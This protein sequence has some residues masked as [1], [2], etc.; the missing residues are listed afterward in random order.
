MVCKSMTG[1]GQ[2]SQSSSAFDVRVELRSVNQRFVEFAL[3][4]SKDLSYLEEPI[5]A[6]LGKHIHRGRVDVNVFLEARSTE[7]KVDIQWDVLRA[8][9]LAEQQVRETLLRDAAPVSI[10]QLLLHPQVTVVTTAPLSGEEVVRATLATLEQATLQ[11][12]T[13]RQR[14]GERLALD[15]RA[16]IRDLF[17][18]VQTIG[19]FAAEIPERYREKLMRRLAE[20]HTGTVDSMRIEQEV[21]LFAERATID[22]EVVRLKSHLVEYEHAFE[23]LGPIGRRLDFLVQEMHREINTIGS[24]STNLEISKAVV[25]AKV[26]IEQLRE[27]AQ[28]IE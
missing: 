20:I 9:V 6:Y 1:F 27:Q 3:R 8:F 13:M 12:M 4:V 10:A 26:L 25:D 15:M 19:T 14:E 22:E 17:R 18:L 24:K 5:R 28:N 11:L 21:V 23:A 16:R 7:K 2:S